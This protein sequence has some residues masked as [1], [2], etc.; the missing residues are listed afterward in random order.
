MNNVSFKY[1][2]RNVPSSSRI[3]NTAVPFRSATEF[4]EVPS[5]SWIECCCDI[6]FSSNVM[7]LVTS[8]QICLLAP[9]S[10]SI[11][12]LGEMCLS[13]LTAKAKEC[14]APSLLLVSSSVRIKFAFSSFALRRH[15]RSV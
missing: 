5:A 13:S 11:I 8:L 4:I 3:W 10:T 9:L 1:D 6:K 2:V 14:S 15:V 7:N 12:L